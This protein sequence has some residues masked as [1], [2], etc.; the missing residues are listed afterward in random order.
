MKL[1]RPQTPRN[2][3]VFM[4]VAGTVPLLVMIIQYCRTLRRMGR[5]ESLASNPN[6]QMA[7]AILLLGTILLISVI[8]NILLL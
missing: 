5:K 7:V 2:L 3:G 4:L 6:L 1:I 8:W